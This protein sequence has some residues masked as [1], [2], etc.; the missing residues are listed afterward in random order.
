MYSHILMGNSHSNGQENCNTVQNLTDGTKLFGN[1]D[2]TLYEKV[3]GRILQKI[4]IF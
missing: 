1:E 3:I 2:H 4:F